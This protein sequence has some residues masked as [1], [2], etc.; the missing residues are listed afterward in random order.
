MA[1]GHV[2]RLMYTSRPVRGLSALCKRRSLNRGWKTLYIL[3]MLL[4]GGCWCGA[5]RIIVIGMQLAY[6]GAA[7]IKVRDYTFNTTN[8]HTY[9]PIP[10]WGWIIGAVAGVLWLIIAGISACARRPFFT[11]PVDNPAA[12]TAAHL[13][14]L[15]KKM[16]ERGCLVFLCP[17][18]PCHT[19][20]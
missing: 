17:A 19:R 11:T 5:R 18:L 14:A 20:T 3:H 8:G 4:N 12:H 9:T 7:V 16:P 1:S 15:E 10:D 13:L 2:E 6:Y